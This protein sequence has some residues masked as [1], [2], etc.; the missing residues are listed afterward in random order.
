MSE[1]WDS[2]E[3]RFELTEPEIHWLD[4]QS[5]FYSNAVVEI[6]AGA[7]QEWISR[8]PSRCVTQETMTVIL[9][10]ALD[11]FIARHKAEF[12]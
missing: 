9:R 8:N 6:L 1:S 2:H 4:Q 10:E 3:V 5:E 11:E 7:L 12:L